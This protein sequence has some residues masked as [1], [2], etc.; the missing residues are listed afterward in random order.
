MMA[1][2]ILIQ[3]EDFARRQ[4]R[5]VFG[6]TALLVAGSMLLGA[7]L[8][9]DADILTLLPRDNPEISVFIDSL[10]DFGSLDTLLVLLE[11]AEGDQAVDHEDLVERLAEK[12]ATLPEIEYIEYRLDESHPGVK[13]IRNNAPLYLDEAGLDRLEAALTDE[14]IRRRASQ[15]RALLESPSSVLLKPLLEA[16]PLGLAPVLYGQWLGGSGSLSVDLSSGYYISSDGSALLMIAKPVRPPQDI[17][18]SERLEAVVWRAYEQSLAELGEEY[19]PGMAAAPRMKLGG[20]YIIA[21]E[22]S[23]L[24][25][26][27]LGRNALVSFLAVT[28]LY[29]FC[30]RRLA[31]IFYS[32]VPLLV[33]QALTFGV[34]V[35]ILGGLNNATAGFTAMLMGLGTDFTVVMYGRYVEERRRG[36]SLATA[37]HRMMGETALGVFTGAITSAGTFGAVCVSRFPGLWDFGFLVACG[38][39]L[40]MVAILFLLPAMIAWNEGGRRRRSQAVPKLYL[41][42]FGI[43]RLLHAAD[44]FPRIVLAVCAGLTLI[45]VGAALKVDLSDSY[46]DLRSPNNR[47]LLVQE[48][49]ARRFGGSF[50]FMIAVTR[51]ETAAEALERNRRVVTRLRP[52]IES[53]EI[54]GYDSLL[55]YLPDEASQKRVMERLRQGADGAFSTRRITETF[56]RALAEKGFR[57]GAFDGYLTGLPGLLSPARVLTVEEVSGG[58]MARLAGRYLKRVNGEVRTATFI[59]TAE[60]RWNEGPPPAFA[61][62]LTAGD[63]RVQVTG[64]NVIGVEIKRLFRADALRA[65]AVGTLVV[66]LLLMLDFRSVRL[67][68]YGLLQLGVGVVWMLGLMSLSGIEMNFVNAFATTMILGV[69]IDYG[70]HMV[71]R[72]WHERVVTSR[73]TLE[74]GKAV[75]MAAL[76]N[77]AGFGTV[78]LS[79][80][81]GIRSMGLV[82]LFGT[83]SCLVTSLTLLPAL[84]KLFPETKASPAPAD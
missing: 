50:D 62:G 13:L 10:E 79:S 54:S 24:I 7:K 9:L 12:L 43:E 33:G 67:T 56:R 53:G 19:A 34:A 15:L 16:D 58:E 83:I 66:A 72:I 70:I 76:T 73:G 55:R 8:K 2:Q 81:P 69:G 26:S 74:T 60:A 78:A 30:Y 28:G 27:D 29:L 4:W 36:A 47:G 11:V 77:I 59:Y 42:S 40:C 48:E 49:V 20:G 22:D 65:L 38:I 17:A 3:I 75:V 51:G 82:C 46:R 64:L 6:I 71:H 68:A 35:V 21:I 44:R 32:V 25:K 80:Y 14:A 63:D 45:A 61:D 31:A 84:L 52:W 57:E 5:L 39:L 18:F 1:R 41:Q 23:K 37:T